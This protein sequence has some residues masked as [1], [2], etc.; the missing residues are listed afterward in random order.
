MN[1]LVLSLGLLFLITKTGLAETLYVTDMLRL[2]VN[3]QPKSQGKLVTTLKSGDTL[4]VL[5]RQPGYAKI[6]TVDGLVGWTKSAYLVVDKPAR[7]IVD[8]KDQQLTSL[9][10]QLADVREQAKEARIEAVKF[11]RILQNSEK[12]VQMQN[13]QLENIQKQNQQYATTTEAFSKSI[14]MNIFLIAGGI[15]FFMGLLLGWYIIDH[16]IRKRHG[17]FR[18]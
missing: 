16:R 1:K 2:S 12:T 15:L 10:A 9:Q 13:A 4:T 7:L 14:P 5:D 17:G 3:E 11:Q 8:E 6:Q 18:I